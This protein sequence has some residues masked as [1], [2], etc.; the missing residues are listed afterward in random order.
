[1]TKT[2][3]TLDSAAAEIKRLKAELKETQKRVKAAEA[4]IES[5][6]NVIDQSDAWIEDRPARVNQKLIEAIRCVELGVH[7]LSFER[8]KPAAPTRHVLTELH[9]T[10]TLMGRQGAINLRDLSYLD[11][12][13]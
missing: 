10:L 4:L 13:A 6:R 2:N 8:I 7:T 5:Q 1:M 12:D 3:L 9:A 11:S